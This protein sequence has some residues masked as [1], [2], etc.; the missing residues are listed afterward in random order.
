M[1][2]PEHDV[3]LILARLRQRGHVPAAETRV[4]AVEQAAEFA[5]RR[6]HVV[7][8]SDGASLLVL[9]WLGAEPAAS[10]QPPR[11][12]RRILPP[13][14]TR[15]LVILYSLLT[16]PYAD[17]VVVTTSQLL[18]VA[19]RLMGRPCNSWLLPALQE[20][21]PQAGLVVAAS[22]GWRAG[23]AMQTWDAPTRDVMEHAARGLWEH[24][25]WS[26]ISN[27]R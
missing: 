14:A 12:S 21:L 9:G 25:S 6:V 17:R 24:P 26:E 22:S 10:A 20:T 1:V 19:E 18:V 8:D 13:K 2:E 23:P 11:L 3:L 27:A 5:G 4:G 7:E 16:D 15:T